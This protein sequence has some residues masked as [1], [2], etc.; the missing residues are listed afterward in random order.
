MAVR[1]LAKDQPADFEFSD[2]TLKFAE[3]LIAKYPEG[4]KASA[5]IPLLWQVQEQNG[6][7]VS[8]PAIRRVGEHLDMPYI[9]VLEIVTFYT[10]FNLAPVGEFHVQVCTTTPCWLRGSD[11]VVAACK[12]H[13]A[14]KQMK[15][16]E[17]GK[18]SWVEVECLG[19]CANAPMLQI[20]DHY[21]D[22]MDRASTETLLQKLRNGE[23]VKV[24][25]QTGRVSSEPS[26]G[27]TSLT[28]ETVGGG[29]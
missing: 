5:V 14:E 9:R 10:M 24:G 21:Y 22:D 18:F 11:D 15:V 1:R 16:S 7:W 12:A 19:A 13:I 8:E 28:D 2:E 3:S 6:G 17:D 25:S 4:R 20:G 27:L 29:E 23:E 26:N